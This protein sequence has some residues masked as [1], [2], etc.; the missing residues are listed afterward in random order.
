MKKISAIFFLLNFLLA[1]VLSVHAEEDQVAKIQKA[2]EGIKDIKGTFVQKSF[3]KD[4]KRTDIHNGRFF[5]KPPK[6]KWEYTGD[7]PQAIYVNGNEVIIY[8]KKENQV[9]RSKFDR[10]TYGQAPISL[11]A[12]FGNIRQEFD[13]VS[14]APDRVVIKPKKAMGNIEHIEIAPSDG[15]F[16]IKSLTIIDSLSNKI[17]ITLKDVRTNTGLKNSVFNFTPPKDA[18]VLEQ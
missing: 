12:G 8:Q 18:S 1:P 11:L 6:M 7:R 17:E 15:V 3:I 16:P 5:I 14:N 10:G 4:L 13:I 9:I 2:Y